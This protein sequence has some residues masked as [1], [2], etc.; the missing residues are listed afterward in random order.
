VNQVLIASAKAATFAEDRTSTVLLLLIGLFALLCALLFARFRI[1]VTAVFGR[2]FR[3]RTMIARRDGKLV[4]YAEG[5]EPPP[6]EDNNDDDDG[7]DE[8]PDPS[9][10]PPS[11][12][13]LPWQPPT[14]RPTQKRTPNVGRRERGTEGGG[15]VRGN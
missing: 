12:R 15:R 2:P 6:N 8:E 14:V 13:P 1:A 10:A 3:E 11:G 4:L 7:P 5:D 9:P